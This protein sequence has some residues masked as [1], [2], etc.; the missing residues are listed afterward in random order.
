MLTCLHKCYIMLS[1][2]KGGGIYIFNIDSINYIDLRLL[3]G[4]VDLI[5]EALELYAFNF[6]KVYAIDKDSDL[7]DLRN[8][9]LYHTYE[10]ILNKKTNDSYRIGYDVSKYCRLEHERKKR[11]IYYSKKKIS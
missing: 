2:H 10:Q 6:H 7:E 1:Y 4:Q 8:C 5:L 11:V 9:L 3:E